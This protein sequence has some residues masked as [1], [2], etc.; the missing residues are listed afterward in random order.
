MYTYKVEVIH[1]YHSTVHSPI[2]RTLWNDTNVR[3]L[4]YVQLVC[5]KSQLHCLSH[6]MYFSTLNFVC[7]LVQDA[8]NFKQLIFRGKT[9]D[10]NEKGTNMFSWNLLCIEG[11]CGAHQQFL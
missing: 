5:N 4:S 1:L 2:C 6:G 10:D 3:L 8:P 11:F 9:L 7:L